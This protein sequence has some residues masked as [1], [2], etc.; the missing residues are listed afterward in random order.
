M[1]FGGLL[2]LILAVTLGVMTFR[3]GYGWLF[4]GIFFPIFSFFGAFMRPA[5]AAYWSSI[6]F[7]RSTRIVS[8]G[9]DG[10]PCSQADRRFA[11][12]GRTTMS[13]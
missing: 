8:E 2:W 10:W 7:D 4:F 5:A 12:C 13:R 9:S 1:G 3:T 11:V 6:S